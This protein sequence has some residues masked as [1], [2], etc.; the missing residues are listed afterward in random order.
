M[1]EEAYL[2]ERLKSL[3]DYF[4]EVELPVT[5][6]SKSRDAFEANNEPLPQI[7]TAIF[8]N[9]WEQV[10]MD[11]FTEYIP[12]FHFVFG[13]Y[14]GIVYWKAALLNYV[15]VL[16]VLDQKGILTDRLELAETRVQGTYLK[17]GAAVI[18]DKGEITMVEGQ[19]SIDYKKGDPANTIAEK[20]QINED[21][22]I[23]EV[24]LEQKT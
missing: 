21:G 4:P 5:L 11:E 24:S 16:V 17:Q 22:Q 15:Y 18:S 19:V 23:R 9:H 13:K 2:H 14:I 7:L 20:W 1:K 10:E 6:T 12:G 8:I 3:L